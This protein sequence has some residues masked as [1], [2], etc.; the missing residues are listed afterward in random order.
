[1]LAG[2]VALLGAC[3][4]D[5]GAAAD[6][7][8]PPTAVSSTVATETRRVP[9]VPPS[10]VPGQTDDGTDGRVINAS[11]TIVAAD[12]A[13]GAPIDPQVPPTTEL[14]GDPQPLPDT[15]SPPPPPTVEAPPAACE[16]LRAQGVD[17]IVADAVTDAV[18]G[19]VTVDAA[20]GNTADTVCRYTAGSI[21]VEVHFVA[22]AV[23]RDDWYRRAGVEPVGEVNGEAV[24]V[25]SFAPPGGAAGDGYTIALVGGRDGVIVAVRGTSDARRVAGQVAIFA[26]QAA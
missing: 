25:G 24:G 12:P 19:A 13:S 20:A 14:L 4:G 6:D 17:G 11:P 9:T 2:V 16:R 23:V 18:G 8:A 21:V 3:S 5:D 7:T 1:M 15:T 10:T 26:D 22:Q